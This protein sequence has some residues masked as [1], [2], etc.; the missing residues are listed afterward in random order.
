MPV[1]PSKHL[2]DLAAALFKADEDFESAAQAL[3]D[4]EDAMASAAKKMRN[5]RTEIAR[6]MHSNGDKQRVVVA[7]NGR[8]FLIDRMN[9]DSAFAT[10]VE[11]IAP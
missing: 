8:H 5:A 2:P 3:K 6:W 10:P 11:F 4:A 1:K 9:I 7:V